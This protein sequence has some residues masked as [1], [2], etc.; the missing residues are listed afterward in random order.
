MTLGRGHGYKRYMI[1]LSVVH[2]Q[3]NYS[4]ISSDV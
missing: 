4:I 3:M 2:E 1:N